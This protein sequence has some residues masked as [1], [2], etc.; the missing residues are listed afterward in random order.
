[1]IGL[2]SDS[3]PSMKVDGIGWH[4]RPLSCE[5]RGAIHV[6][7]SER[8]CRSPVC[9]PN[10]SPSR[11]AD[12]H[13][14]PRAKALICRFASPR[15]VGRRRSEEEQERADHLF[16]DQFFREGIICDRYDSI[17]KLWDPVWSPHHSVAAAAS[18]TLASAQHNTSPLWHEIKQT[19]NQTRHVGQ[20]HILNLPHFSTESNRGVFACLFSRTPGRRFGEKGRTTELSSLH[21]AESRFWVTFTLGDRAPAEMALRRPPATAHL[22]TVRVAVP[23]AVPRRAERRVEQ[24]AIQRHSWS[25]NH[26]KSQLM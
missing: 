9:H 8:M 21:G 6:R 3:R 17:E 20:D 14:F 15:S 11:R 4:E 5:N 23:R 2:H 1:M 12:C 16:R 26:G 22:S 18:R 13:C 25:E 19:Q 24:T 7:C 10:S